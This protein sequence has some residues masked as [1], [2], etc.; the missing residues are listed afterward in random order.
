MLVTENLDGATV[1]RAAALGV[2]DIAAPGPAALAR[3]VDQLYL[4]QIWANDDDGTLVVMFDYTIDHQVLDHVMCVG[5]DAE[6]R[7]TGIELE[8]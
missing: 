3:F 2:E 8:S 7:I 5:F 1:E 4:R 6:G